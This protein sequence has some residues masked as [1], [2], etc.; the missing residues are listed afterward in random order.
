MQLYEINVAEKMKFA[1]PN[2]TTVVKEVLARAYMAVI[3]ESVLVSL[4]VE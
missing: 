4:T 2:S 1:L 3:H